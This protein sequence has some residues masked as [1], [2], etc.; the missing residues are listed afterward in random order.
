VALI[1]PSLERTEEKACKRTVFDPA[2]M[3]MRNIKQ[4]LMMILVCYGQAVAPCF[5]EAPVP[6]AAS[7]PKVLLIGDSISGGYSKGV[8]KLLEGKASVTGPLSNAE[9]TIYGVARLDE[10][11]GDAKWDLIH[12]N[13]GLW[14]IYGWRYAKEDR[15]PAMY[16]KRLEQLVTRL[17]KT[18]ATLIW[19]TTTPVC[20]EAETTMLKQ[21]KTEV[22]I[23][24]ETEK[25]YRD[26]ALRVMTRHGVQ[27]NDLHAAIK[28]QQEKVQEPDNVH[29]SGAGYGLLAK[30]VAETIA[31]SLGL[32]TPTQKHQ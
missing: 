8:K 16:E 7:L 1:Q 24:P 22:K 15:S 26:A 32:E 12:F 13:W 4:S 14:D 9:T 17:E 31:A 20:R 10:W 19:A 18:G 30:Q 5:A 28:P 11:L 21:F 23:T 25:E 6:N 27:V 3:P 29:F 2:H